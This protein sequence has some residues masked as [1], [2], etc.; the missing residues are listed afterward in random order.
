MGN[1]MKYYNYSVKNV[2]EQSFGEDPITEMRKPNDGRFTSDW[3]Q[4]HIL[5]RSWQYADDEARE[6]FLDELFLV[7]TILE[8]DYIA[9]IIKRGNANLAYLMFMTTEDEPLFHIDTQYAK[10]LIS[11]WKAKGYETKILRVCID[12]VYYDNDMSKGYHFKAHVGNRYGMALHEMRKVN[13]RDILVF[14]E[15]SCWYYYYRKLIYVSKSKDVKEYECLFAPDVIITT[16]KE[17]E[18]TVLQTGIGALMDYF[19]YRAPAQIAYEEFENTGV[20]FCGLVAGDDSIILTVGRDNLISEINISQID[21]DN[22]LFDL[23]DNTMESLL[24]SIPAI[25]CIRLLDPAQVHA[26]AFQLDYGENNIRNYYFHTFSEKDIPNQFVLEGRRFNADVLNSAVIK[27]QG[28]S[29][30]NGYYIPAHILYYRSRRQV[31]VS[32]TGSCIYEDS[33]LRLQSVY[34]LPLQEFHGHFTCRQYFG[35]RDECFGPNMA[36]LDRS[37]RRIIDAAFFSIRK[38]YHFTQAAKACIEPTGKFGLLKTDGTWLTPP[39]YDSL[40]LEYGGIAKASRNIGARKENLLINSEG[41]EIP[42]TSI[43]E[44]S[45]TNDRAAFS[46]EEWEGKRPNPGI[47]YDYDYVKPGKWGFI[48][49]KGNVVVEPQYVYAVGFY[50]SDGDHSIVAKFVDGKLR[51][52]VVDWNGNEVIPCRYAEIYDVWGGEALAYRSDDDSY[53]YGVIDYDGTVLQEPLFDS[54]KGYD[55]KHKLIAAGDDEDHL[56][57]FSIELQKMITPEVFDCIDF[58]EHVME[59]EVAWECKDRIFDYDGN[60]IILEGC[61]RVSESEGMFLV[62]KNGK[63]GFFDLE[64]KEIIPPVLRDGMTSSFNLYKR[65]YVITGDKKCYGLSKTTGEVIIPEKF[66]EIVICGDYVIASIRNGGNWCFNDTLYSIDGTVILKGLYKNMTIDAEKRVLTVNTPNGL[67]YID[68]I[69][70]NALSSDEKK[71]S[72]VWML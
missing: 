70:E 43:D 26:Y 56:G 27:S 7:D 72:Q 42:S 29:F 2:L 25:K 47:Y 40:D 11:E 23:A 55:R 15:T 62:W 1:R 14:C 10:Y 61:E 20:F 67:E 18:K 31:Q 51:W 4:K 33:H 36:F 59:C 49:S 9:Y 63:A 54:I 6:L 46:V 17:K 41:E 45:F 64:G 39:I 44:L 21:R 5:G 16:G 71:H 34:R 52:G 35:F 12:I 53:L 69:T 48:D 65:G 50:N 28:I 19:A 66:S 60:E 30:S 8:D 32:T 57:V 37:G 24:K 3:D 22:Y 58:E 68:I 38:E 13:G